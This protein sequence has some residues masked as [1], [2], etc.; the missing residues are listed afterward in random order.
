MP[1]VRQKHVTASDAL[2]QIADSLDQVK[3]VEVPSFYEFVRDI[4]SQSFEHPE[5][6]NAWHIGV[7]CEDIERALDEGLNYAA[8]LPRYHFKSTVLGHAFSVW[9]LLGSKTDSNILY[10][11]YSDGM[12]QYHVSEINKAVRRN[13]QLVEWMDDKSPQADFSFRWQQGTRQLDIPHGGLFSFK[14][15]LHVNAGLIA[16]DILRDPDNPL[17]LGQLNKIEEHF[18]TESMFIPVK[19]APVIVIGTPMAPSDILAKLQDDERFIS[20]VLPALDPEPGR[21]VLM[22]ELYDEKFLLTQ[23]KANPRSFAS[24]MLLTPYLSTSSYFSDTD[25]KKIEDRGLRSLNP[26]RDHSKDIDSDFTVAGFDIGKKRHPSHLV[27]YKSVGGQLEQIHQSFLDGWSYTEQIQF[28]NKVAKNFDVDKAYIDNTRGELE[29][30]GLDSVWTP[31]YFT[32]KNKRTMAQVWEKYV[33]A[34][35]MSMIADDRQRSQITCVDNELRAPETP[36]GHGD[37]F[38]SNAMAVLAFDETAERGTTDLGDMHLFSD[39]P[40]SL[41]PMGGQNEPWSEGD[42]SGLKQLEF[43]QVSTPSA[44]CPQ[45]GETVGWEQDSMLCLICLYR[46][47][48]DGIL[49]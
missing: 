14:R 47:D 17:N 1:Q 34:E 43:S 16:D 19:G 25:M 22:P 36:M 2:N 44:S 39:G 41:E 8:V 37:A 11:S 4:W 21:R 20:R 35:K 7:V 6:F 23:Q 13:P 31:L 10:L 30:R 49:K 28:L 3:F 27:I 45:C 29:E 15:G 5:Y 48:R 9:R 18:M 12:A 32:A 24:E 38:F 42:G 26:N 40:T 33:Y 46:A